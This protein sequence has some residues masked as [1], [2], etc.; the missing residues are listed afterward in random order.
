MRCREVGV[1]HDRGRVGVGQDDAVALSGEHAARLRA[2]VVELARLTDHD[3]AAADQQDRLQVVARGTTR[4]LHQGAEL[5]EQIAGVVGTGPRL[6]VVLH[7]EGRDVATAQ[8]LDDAVVQVDVG[9]VGALDGPVDDRVVVVL[10]G[11]LDR[12]RLQPPHRVVA[13][14]VTELQLEG[15]AVERRASS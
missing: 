3:R 7:A 6:R 13:A 15:V 1:G 9:D 12:V 10:A 11:D 4:P 2:R 14:V 5:L 8:A